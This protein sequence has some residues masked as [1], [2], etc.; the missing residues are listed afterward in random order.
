MLRSQIW[1]FSLYAAISLF[2]V[3]LLVPTV[4][5]QLPQ[6]WSKIVPSEKIRLGLDLQGG[7]YL[8]LGVEAQ[9]A[10]ES[11]LEQIKSSLQDGLKEQVIPVTN[12]E[13]EKTGQIVLEFSGGWRRV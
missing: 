7:M 10:L 6:W 11:Y 1:K 2:A 4:T 12:L 13:T 5:T 3:L 8:L 9:E